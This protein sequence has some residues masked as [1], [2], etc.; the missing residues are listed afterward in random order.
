M[1]D[2]TPVGVF[3]NLK[4]DAS[5]LDYRTENTLSARFLHQRPID[6]RFRYTSSYLNTSLEPFNENVVQGSP[7]A[8]PADANICRFES[9]GKLRTGKLNPLIA[10][11]EVRCGHLQ[12]SI[13]G[14]QAKA[15]IQRD[16]DFSCQYIPTEPIDNR[17]QIHKPSRHSD[18]GD[19][20]TPDLIASLDA[21]ATQ[22][23]RIALLAHSRNTQVRFGIDRLQ[24]HHAQ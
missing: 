21:H 8:I 23:I 12:C 13:Q 11:E 22:Q 19:I 10:I 20:T 7:S 3:D 18:V 6:T 1:I 9:V 2:N 16:R 24:A 5:D 15:R 14:I 17:H 4:L